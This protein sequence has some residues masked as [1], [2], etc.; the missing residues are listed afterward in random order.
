VP[1]GDDV[2]ELTEENRQLREEIRRLKLGA[3]V[4]LSEENDHLIEENKRLLK[5][6][7]IASYNIIELTA[8]R[9]MLSK[10]LANALNLVSA[11]MDDLRH[12]GVS[13]SMASVV[14]KTKLD[15][16]TRAL[17]QRYGAALGSPED[18][19]PS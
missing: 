17:I 1:N 19:K 6:R 11:M 13:P 16:E 12:A 15:Y 5:T 4:E 14:M 18:V 8:Q 7:E 2:G 3:G 9:D 10:C